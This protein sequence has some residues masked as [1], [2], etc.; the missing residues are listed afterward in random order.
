MPAYRNPTVRLMRRLAIPVLIVGLLAACRTAPQARPVGPS[1]AAPAAPL[2]VLSLD[3]WRWDYHTKTTL[4]ALQRL[5]ASGVRAE[6]LVPGFP[7]KTFPNHYSIVTG[8]YPGHHGVIGNAMA[9]PGIAGRFTLANREQVG[10]AAWW[11]GEPLWVTVIRQGRPAAALF[12]PGS[13][14]PIGGVRPSEWT[15]YDGSMPNDQRVDRLLEW[16]ERPIDRRPALL[17]TYF[18]DAD[19]AGHRFGPDSAELIDALLRVDRAIGRLMAGLDARGLTG[20]VNVVLVSDHGM[21]TVSRDRVIALSDYLDLA[22]VDVVDVNP[23]LAIAPMTMT[24]DEVYRRLVRAHPHLHV[25]RKAETPAH[26]RFRTHPRVPAIAWVSPTKAGASSAGRSPPR[27]AS[28]WACT[29]TIRRSPRCTACSSPAAR[30]FA[31]TPSCRRSTASTSTTCWPACSG[32]ALH[33][34]TAIPA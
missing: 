25:Y 2:I 34:T 4:P 33:Q 22:A 3:G 32:S 17:L 8:L 27:T 9:D 7:T 23:N 30:L 11:G 6:R 1:T 28:R 15:P 19:D 13:E 14:A 21:A 12:W 5:I 20:R 16:L 31:G 26:W 29:A 24:E 10:N 18:S